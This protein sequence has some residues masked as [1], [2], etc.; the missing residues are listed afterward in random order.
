MEW[1][2]NLEQQNISFNISILRKND[3]IIADKKTNNYKI[4][5]ILDGFIHKIQNFTNGETICLRLLYNNDTFTNIRNFNKTTNQD[6]NY[7]YTFK[8]LSKTII[9]IIK[10]KEFTSKI[11]NNNQ[12]LSNF[13]Y[14]SENTSQQ[15]IQILSHKN[16]KKR[17]IQ[18]LIVLIEHFGVIYKYNIIIPFNL[19][20]YNIATIIGSQRITVNRIMNLLKKNILFTTMK[21]EL[22]F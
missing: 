8:A 4:I 22:L 3:C 13:F 20:H 11:Q 21:Q 6:I 17:L 14:A 19:S 1:L 10:Q 2:I 18:L 9:L 5:Y 12:L 15:I 7:Y 16:T